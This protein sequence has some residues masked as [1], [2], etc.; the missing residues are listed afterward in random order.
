MRALR[1][2]W[3]YDGISSVTLTFEDSFGNVQ[4]ILDSKTLNTSFQF[5]T[6][7]GWAVGKKWNQEVREKSSEDDWEMGWSPGQK[8]SP[9]PLANNTHYN[10]YPLPI[11]ITL[12]NIHGRITSPCPQYCH[13]HSVLCRTLPSS[14]SLSSTHSQSGPTKTKQTSEWGGLLQRWH[15]WHWRGG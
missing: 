14:A 11:T 2:C 10:Q 9:L 15:K 8:S 3:T 13:H 4:T 12:P 7:L 6:L 5:W 1:A